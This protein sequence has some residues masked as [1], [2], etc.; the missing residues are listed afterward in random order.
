V[1]ATAEPGGTV[2]S[3]DKADLNALANHAERVTIQ[4][5]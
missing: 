1:V 5:V 3:G 2:L 4:P